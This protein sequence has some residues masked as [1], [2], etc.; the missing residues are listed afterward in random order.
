MYQIRLAAHGINFLLQCKTWFMEHTKKNDSMSQS[1]EKRGSSGKRNS[2]K[3]NSNGTK[4]N[5]KQSKKDMGMKQER[6]SSER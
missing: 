2:G 1:K 6:R 3:N 5:N 4:S